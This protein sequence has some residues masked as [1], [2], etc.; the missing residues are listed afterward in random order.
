[1]Q[2]F[3]WQLGPLTTTLL[4]EWNSANGI[5]WEAGTST[6]WHSGNVADITSAF[7]HKHLWHL[8]DVEGTTSDRGPPTLP[9]AHLLFV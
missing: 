5:V 7:G 6:Y 9:V 2:S 1:M 4:T 8:S 3:S